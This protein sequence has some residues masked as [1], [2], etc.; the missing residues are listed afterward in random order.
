MKFYNFVNIALVMYQFCMISSTANGMDI[1]LTY[2]DSSA[3]NKTIYPR[4]NL[5]LQDQDHSSQTKVMYLDKHLHG[6]TVV[7]KKNRLIQLK[8]VKPN[9]E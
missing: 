9:T 3:I 4:P 8:A 6:V 1:N 5:G 2:P 7:L